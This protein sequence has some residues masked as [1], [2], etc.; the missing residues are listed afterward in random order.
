MDTAEFKKRLWTCRFTDY[1]PNKIIRTF[2][3]QAPTWSSDLIIVSGDNKSDFPEKIDTIVEKLKK[4][5]PVVNQVKP[6]RIS[7]EQEN[8]VVSKYKNRND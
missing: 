3:H 2:V 6:N 4:R 8:S 1:F 5:L 7:L